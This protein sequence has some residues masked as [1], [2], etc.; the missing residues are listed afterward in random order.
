MSQDGD[1]NKKISNSG[2][3]LI[4]NAS[5]SSRLGPLNG[6]AASHHFGL[7]PIDD[8]HLKKTNH[9]HALSTRDI[10]GHSR[11]EPK[12]YVQ[13][14]KEGRE[15]HSTSKL[16]NDIHSASFDQGLI[17]A[18][19]Y[20]RQH[21]NKKIKNTLAAHIIQKWFREHHDRKINQHKHRSQG[22]NKEKWVGLGYNKANLFQKEEVSVH[23]AQSPKKKANKN[24]NSKQYGKLYGIHIVKTEYRYSI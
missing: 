22:V 23:R 12:S 14:W 7:N 9:I 8:V 2:Q 3:T 24:N 10:D 6:A 17:V 16:R 11:D 15:S 19:T 1:S 13:L 21:Q 5:D 18:N 4:Q 20:S